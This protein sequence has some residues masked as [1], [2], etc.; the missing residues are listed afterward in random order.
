MRRSRVGQHL[1][2]L[3][4]FRRPDVAATLGLVEPARRLVRSQYDDLDL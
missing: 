3:V 4:Q 2:I 1:A